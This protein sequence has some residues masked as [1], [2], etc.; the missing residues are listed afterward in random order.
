M[1][2]HDEDA[3]RLSQNTLTLD[4]FLIQEAEHYEPPKLERKAIVHGHCHH[5]SIMG[6][7]AERKLLE[8]LGLNFEILDS[9]CCG[10]AG[11]W[12]FEKEHY[13]L[14][15]QI[16]ERRLLPAARSAERDTLI[17]SDGFS[18]KTQIEHATDRRALHIAQVIKMAMDHGSSGSRGDYP[19]GG[20]PDV[21]LN[22]HK[23]EI[24]AAAAAGA[25]VAGGALGW[26]A[27]KRR[28]G[29]KER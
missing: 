7:D 28:C 25:A 10:L 18:C 15:M 8:E 5:K 27:K 22:G 11:S 2:P 21:M 17:I 24:K 19:E 23:P 9:G 4:E 12:G 16:G 29:W 13:D 26:G 3:K 6:M 14:S 1:L 20:S